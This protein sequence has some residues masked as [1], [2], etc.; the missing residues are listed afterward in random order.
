MASAIKFSNPTTVEVQSPHVTYQNDYM[1]AQYEY[2]TTR[3]FKGENDSVIAKPETTTYT[4]R[5]TTTVPKVGVMMVGWGGNNGSTVTGAILANKLGISWHDREGLKQAN[6]WGSVTQASTL[7]LGVDEDNNDVFVPFK[8][9]LPMADPNKLVLGGWDINAAN[10]SE[11]MERAQVFEYD[12]RRQLSEHMRDLVPL[13]GIYYPDFIAANQA[14]RADNILPGADKQQHLDQLRKDIRDFKQANQLDKVIVLWTANTE[15]FADISCGVNQTAD[16]LLASVKAS[17][18]EIAPSTIYAMAAVL[19]GCSFINGSPQN[20]CVPGLVELAQRHGVFLGGDDFKS[21]QTKMKSV[22]V[23]FLVNAGIKPVSITSYNHLGNNDG[24]N[25]SAPSQFRSK[26]I[27][28]SNVVDDMVAANGILYEEGEHPDHVVVIKYVP[29]V[30]DSKRAM[31]EYMSK[32]FMHGTNTIAMHNTCEDS[33]LAS[34]LII[35]LVVICELM[36]RIQWKTNAVPDFHSF[37]TICS[38]LSYLLKA[39]LV[40]EGAPVV[41]ALFKQREAVGNLLRACLGLAPDNQMGLEHITT[42]QVKSM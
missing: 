34:P 32:I 20:T 37:A 7:K 17:H 18:A 35:D 42:R 9:M 40:P 14:D 39:P 31:D 1:E 6:Y 41:N 28:K 22:L 30:G 19:E 2:T 4:L 27:S 5:T 13:K 25:L 33:L 26:E 21:G 3:V 15:R 8:S 23:D 24:K 38:P 11:A 12:L 36:E 29:S 16:E 10:L